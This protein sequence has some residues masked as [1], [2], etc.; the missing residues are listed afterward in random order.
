ML[1]L[2]CSRSFVPVGSLFATLQSR[3]HQVLLGR[4][5]T[6]KT[7]VM[8]FLQEQCSV[9]GALAI[10][11][12]LRQIG[13]AEDVF[14]TE[15]ENFAEQATSLLVDVVEHASVCRINRSSCI[16]GAPA[17][18]GPVTRP[19]FPRWVEHWPTPTRPRWDPCV[20]VVLGI[21][22]AFGGCEG[23]TPSTG[24]ADI[25]LAT[26][27]AR[28]VT[29]SPRSFSSPAT[30]AVN[31]TCPGRQ[32]GVPVDGGMLKVS[33]STMLVSVVLPRPHTSNEF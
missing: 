9:E 3:E 12:D 22:T 25:L 27:G 5:G 28:R 33:A 4:R 16:T 23:G 18:P 19:W 1:P 6:G 21:V 13:A 10:Y 31:H 11:L 8:R 26:V 14:S 17:N 32:Q 30:S 2:R 29:P 20:M 7:H 24:T 15:Q